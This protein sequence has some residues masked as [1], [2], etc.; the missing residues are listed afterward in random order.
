LQE[1]DDGLTAVLTLAGK[2]CNVYGNDV[3]V[4]NLRV[5]YQSENRLAVQITPA[6]VVRLSYCLWFYTRYA[7]LT[8]IGFNQLVVVHSPGRCDSTSAIGFNEWR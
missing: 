4:L 8:L 7:G 5:E 2:P 3:D 6:N 1:K